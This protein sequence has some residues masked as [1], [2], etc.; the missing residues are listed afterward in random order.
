MKL[1]NYIIFNWIYNFHFTIYEYSMID[2]I[3]GNGHGIGYIDGK[4]DLYYNTYHY[5][6]NA[7]WN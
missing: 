3:K 6:V 2:D 7:I 1:S 4:P 5:D